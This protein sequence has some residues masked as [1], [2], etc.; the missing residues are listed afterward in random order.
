MRVIL[1]A[2]QKGGAGKSTLACHFA[3]LAGTARSPALLIDADPQGS[4]SYWHGLRDRELPL[5]VKSAGG[6]AAAILRD[7]EA[8]GIGTVIVDSAPHNAPA[9]AEWVR[10]ADLIAVPVRPGLFDLAAAAVTFQMVQSLK[11][12]AVAVLNACPPPGAHGV[13]SIAQEARQALE[14]QGVEVLAGQVSQRAALGHA[15]LS[16]LAV[17]EF[18]PDSR[19]AAEIGAIWR[20]IDKRTR[21][22]Q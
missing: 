14:G 11:G 22:G 4:L 21:G 10:A 3:V 17:A 15:L 2:S 18:E 6:D 19:A 7:A 1:I 16:G 9:L 5:L 20:Q 13:P 8:S 12:Q